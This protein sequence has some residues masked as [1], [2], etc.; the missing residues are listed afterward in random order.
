MRLS[1]TSC[2]K[3]KEFDT[4]LDKLKFVRTESEEMAQKVTLLES[5]SRVS[6]GMECLSGE[7]KVTKMIN[8]F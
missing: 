6:K 5:Y 1:I 7:D 8:N 2:A 4:F 3:S